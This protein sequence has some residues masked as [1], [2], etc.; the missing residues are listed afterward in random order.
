LRPGFRQSLLAEAVSRE[1]H[2]RRDQ[3]RVVHGIVD[4]LDAYA[5]LAGVEIIGTEGPAAMGAERPT[6]R[7]F[8][9]ASVF[10]LSFLWT[11]ST[12]CVVRA[13]D[14]C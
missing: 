11:W 10:F 6:I 4:C 7:L 8:S 13:P 12:S 5:E 2:H 1:H 14:S 3:T 9:C